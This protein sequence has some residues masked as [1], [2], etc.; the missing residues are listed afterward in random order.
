MSEDIISNNIPSVSIGDAVKEISVLYCNAIKYKINFKRIPSVMMWGPPGVGKSQAVRQ[1][2][3]IIEKETGKKVKITDVRLLLFNP[4][5]LRGIPTSNKDKTLAVWL[6][7]QIFQMAEDDDVINILF[8]DEISAAP[9]S[10]QAA[11]YQ[12]TLDR[13][14]GEHQLPDNCL[15][16][17]AGNRTTDKSVS[18]KMPKALSNRLMHFEIRTSF[19]SWKSWADRKGVNPQVID[20]LSHRK[21]DLMMFS[22]SGDDLA[23]ATPRTWEMV[24]DI[25]NI[26]N[27]KA[28]EVFNLIA[29]LIGIDEAV[30]FQ[31]FCVERDELPEIDKIFEGIEHVVPGTPAGLYSVVTSM[32]RYAEGCKEDTAKI[33]NSIVYATKLPIE[34]SVIL[35]KEYLNLGEDFK[36]KIM[37]MPEFSKMLEK[38]GSLLNGFI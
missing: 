14:V 28:N 9:Q 21:S 15:V 23:F 37:A 1:L 2:A 36:R 31:D 32:S 20:F 4:I 10:V 26:S 25:L 35:V 33:R 22:E 38:N 34:Y 11:A 17:A 29:G 3:E 30:A 24:S 12:I 6:R 13:T 16:I 27:C 8:L 19:D 18:F 5:D 7:P